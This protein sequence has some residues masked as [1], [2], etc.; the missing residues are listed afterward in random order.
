MIV[1]STDRTSCLCKSYNRLTFTIET[2]RDRNGEEICERTKV[3]TLCFRANQAH[4][5]GRCGIRPGWEK[6]FGLARSATDCAQT[7]RVF[8]VVSFEE[9]WEEQ[10]FDWFSFV[11]QGTDLQI[12]QCV[13]KGRGEQLTKG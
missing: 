7:G 12:N 6:E 1:C 5:L 2:V 10:R 4:H 8:P 9:L 13:V 11:V 3:G